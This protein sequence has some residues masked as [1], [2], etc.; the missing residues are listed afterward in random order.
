MKKLLTVLFCT[1]LYGCSALTP[2]N[3]PV[4]W[5]S[6]SASI[7]NFTELSARVAFSTDK[8]KPYRSE[9]CQAVS[10]ILPV[11]RSYN[12]P[13]ATFEGLESY[14]V[15]AL[16]NSSIRNK[17][18]ASLVVQGVMETV[19]AY[20]VEAYSTLIKQNLTQSVATVA[21]AVATGLN[22]A[23]VG[24][25]N[26]QSLQVTRFKPTPVASTP[27]KTSKPVAKSVKK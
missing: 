6:M 13:N 4:D 24:T 9:L 8:V 14:V 22:N 23:C 17:D 27:D 2:S 15:N 12:D 16:R 20:A 5:N 11:L 18:V 7:S 19:K 1:M 26:M 3:T 10:E 21:Q 25:G